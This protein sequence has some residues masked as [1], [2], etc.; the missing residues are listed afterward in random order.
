MFLVLFIRAGKW[1]R[2][3]QPRVVKQTVYKAQLTR[4]FTSATAQ[5]VVPADD[6]T[7]DAIP[8]FTL[9]P[10][11]EECVQSCL[12]AIESGMNRIGVS[13]PTGSGKTTI[14]CTLI[15]RMLPI[16][17]QADRALILV[18]SIELARQAAAQVELL[19][20][21]LKVEIEQG[22][23]YRASGAADV[24][25]ATYQ[26]LN[27][28]DRLVKF[29]PNFYKVVVVDE[30]HHAAAPSYLR[31]LSHFNTAIRPQSASKSS[32][33]SI[34]SATV[35]IIGFSATFSRHDGQALGKV[36]QHIVYH[37]DFVEMMKDN[38][39]C[40]TTLTVVRAQLDLSSVTI[41]SA[42]G[43]FTPSSLAQ[44][45]NT[46]A[47]NELVMRT[48]LDR[49][50]ERKSTLVFCVNVQHVKDLT[51]VFRKA[52]IDARYVTGST[53]AMER[54]ELLDAFRRAD[55]PVLVNCA[56]L[57]EGADVPNIDCVMVARP[58]RSRNLFAQI[59]GRGMRLSP[60]TGK[61]NCQIIDFVDSLDRVGNI[62]SAPTLLGVEPDEVVE[63]KPVGPTKDE[64]REEG[65]SAQRSRVQGPKP[66]S[67]TY[68]DYDDP[69]SLAADATGS[70]HLTRLSPFAWVQCGPTIWVLDCLGRGFLKIQKAVGDGSPTEGGIAIA[71]GTTYFNATYTPA[72]DRDERAMGASP[73]MRKRRI[74]TA[75]TL[76]SAI[77][78]CDT[79]ATGKV[80]FG[81][82]ALGLR[83]SAAWRKQ[84][85]T[86]NQKA[87]LQ[88]RAAS[89]V[90]AGPPNVDSLST[91]GDTSGVVDQRSHLS[92]LT[93]GQAANI[94]TRV[95]H[96]AYSYY[97]DKLKKAESV[98]KKQER[99]RL[100]RE[101]HV[102]RVGPLGQMHKVG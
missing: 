4:S 85:A 38:W 98:T 58:T 6:T 29:D 13:S 22:Q 32:A 65:D 34:P 5:A 54:K 90:K 79:Y 70:P 17:P 19:C 25:V 81:H 61:K 56:I 51:A 21:G 74:L 30:A 2:P 41:N 37:K 24:T 91:A 40:R 66:K 76:D 52:G 27:Q 62:V 50:S 8:G 53:P 60:K 77:R 71:A 10:Y 28:A 15:N 57:T 99:D 67:V 92:A 84:P 86:D 3:R 95:K 73:F 68:I 101:G 102:V 80:V 88:K 11:Q 82:L 75:D 49:A 31:I 63:D 44:V 47:I 55:F 93:K 33:F 46:E 36:F 20:P 7:P 43:D 59:I 48:W 26:T 89:L 78:G 69:F 12:T 35:P 1:L 83:R 72:I 64:D 42:S 45:V 94:M 97:S 9:R 39:L 16:T 14:F 87:M 96:G 18:G 23:K 100:R